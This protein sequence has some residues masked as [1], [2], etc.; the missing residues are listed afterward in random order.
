VLCVDGPET[1]VSLCCWLLS[2]TQVLTLVL[3]ASLRLYISD[4]GVC[5][6]AFLSWLGF[7]QTV[8]G[9]LDESSDEAFNLQRALSL[10]S[11]PTTQA[12]GPQ[13]TF[14]SSTACMDYMPLPHESKSHCHMNLYTTRAA[15][16]IK[17]T[18]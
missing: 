11:W 7:E 4:D 17:Q 10:S 8:D 12:L 9:D 14:N 1:F 2:G 13:G 18:C 5:L 15:L 6:Q 3:A 16:L